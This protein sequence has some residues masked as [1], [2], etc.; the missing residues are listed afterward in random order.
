MLAVVASNVSKN[1]R[2]QACSENEVQHRRS[3][4]IP[5]AST[6]GLRREGGALIHVHRNHVSD[7]LSCVSHCLYVKVFIR[8]R[9]Q[10][11]RV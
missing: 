3:Q 4:R 6:V 8:D 9:M 11:T 7:Q 1:I 2:N 10:D 5:V